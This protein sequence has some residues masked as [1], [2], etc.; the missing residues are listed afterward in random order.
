MDT[1]DNIKNKNKSESKVKSI[2][3][4]CKIIDLISHYKNGMRLKEISKN[5]DLSLS[6]THHIVRTLLN[7]KLLFKNQDSGKYCLGFK[8]GE[9]G[10]RYY[11]N[12]PFYE[13]L[14]PYLERLKNEFNETANL[15]VI[16]NSDFVLAESLSSSH[17]LQPIISLNRK[18]IHATAWGKILLS[19]F[20]DENLDAF[21]KKYDFI[22]FTKNT[23]DNQEEIKKEINEIRKNNISFDNEELENDLCCVGIPVY[24]YRHHLIAAITISVPKSR[25][26]DEIKEKLVGS[27]LNI[28]VEIQNKFGKKT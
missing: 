21:L 27:M 9:L 8:I 20:N 23:I 18:Q 28:L 24:G 4:A 1:E 16:E 19:S 10:N 7:N 6:S 5:M 26:N 14:M 12:L 13:N 11:A 25:F 2:D 3:K 22:K 15:I 17:S